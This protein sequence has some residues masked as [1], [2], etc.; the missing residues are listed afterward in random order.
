MTRIP[1]LKGDLYVDIRR[2][3]ADF[4]ILADA[5]FSGLCKDKAPGSEG[6]KRTTEE[7]AILMPL[8]RRRQSHSWPSRFG[9]TQSLESLLCDRRQYLRDDKVQAVIVVEL[10][11]QDR[12]KI[13]DP[14]L[15]ETRIRVFGKVYELPVGELTE[16]VTKAI[17][18]EKIK[19][20][21]DRIAQH[22]TREK[23]DLFR[24]W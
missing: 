20:V 21:I 2:D 14:M 12:T 13:L 4:Y 7:V 10:H 23:Q 6:Y 22:I 9:I 19:R 17:E 24:D 5:S 1:L 15:N 16:D 3:I 8:W 18:D 11:E